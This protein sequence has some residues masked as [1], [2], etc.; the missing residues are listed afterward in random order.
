MMNQ[1]LCTFFDPCAPSRVVGISRW[2]RGMTALGIG[3]IAVGTG[4]SN[5]ADDD[6]PPGQLFH[7]SLWEHRVHMEG[8]FP[9][10]SESN[11]YL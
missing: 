10:H 6:A 4:G 8:Q 7:I 9:L 5:A 2:T 1:S 3:S 11:G